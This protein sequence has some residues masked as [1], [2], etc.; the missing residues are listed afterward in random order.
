MEKDGQGNSESEVGE[1]CSKPTSRGLK[2]SAPGGFQ[3]A[4]DVARTMKGGAVKPDRS[5][6]KDASDLRKL[7]HPA[8]RRRVRARASVSRVVPCCRSSRRCTSDPPWKQPP[9]GVSGHDQLAPSRPS[10][11]ARR[12]VSASLAIHALESEC[13]GALGRAA[14]W[15]GVSVERHA[16]VV[17]RC[18]GVGWE[19]RRSVPDFCAAGTLAASSVIGRGD[20][21]SLRRR[22]ATMTAAEARGRSL[23]ELRVQEQLP[24]VCDAATGAV[25]PFRPRVCT[26]ARC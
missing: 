9:P 17:A 15:S 26:N 4:R 5:P 22:G 10:R 11:A 18:G 25:L 19:V 2:V 24:C 13:N 8:V 3:E 21:G 23:V 14:T 16:G 12:V 7:A 1:S 20:W 6:E